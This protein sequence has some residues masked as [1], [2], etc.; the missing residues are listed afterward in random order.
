MTGN[1]S[2]TGPAVASP[3]PDHTLR[4]EMP[5]GEDGPM[6]ASVYRWLEAMP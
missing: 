6:I 4:V 5:D 2:I 1:Q 3:N